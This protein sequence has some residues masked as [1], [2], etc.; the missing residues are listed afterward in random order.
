MTDSS[1]Y[2]LYDGA[3]CLQGRARQRVPSL[4][5][6]NPRAVLRRIWS[7][8]A[9][10]R[11]RRFLAFTSVR[12]LAFIRVFL[13]PSRPAERPR[14]N[15]DKLQLCPKDRTNSAPSP[16]CSGPWR[17]IALNR[18]MWVTLE[19]MDGPL[20][21]L[22]RGLNQFAPVEA[23]TP[24]LRQSRWSVPS[25][26][27]DSSSLYSTVLQGAARRVIALQ[28]G[29]Y[30]RQLNARRSVPVLAA[31][32]RRTQPNSWSVARCHTDRSGSSQGSR[33]E[34]SL[35]ETSLW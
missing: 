28:R 20:H 7:L 3:S 23:A 9:S 29:F 15:D 11:L 16:T 31:S 8:T 17:P 5:V 32:G 6:Q 35:L 13:V 14:L 18:R 25:S 19:A 21:V 33:H 24:G 26:F 4:N 10:L 34:A 12:T 30:L 2:R 1:E 27:E 22:V